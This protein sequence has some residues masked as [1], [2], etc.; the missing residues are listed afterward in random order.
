MLTSVF[1]PGS[2]VWFYAVDPAS[3]EL[4]WYNS[5]LMEEKVTGRAAQT[6]L[7]YV[8]T[9][10]LHVQVKIVTAGYGRVYLKSTHRYCIN[11]ASSRAN[12]FK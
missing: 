11:V 5:S 3:Q 2:D 1:L 12:L 4:L 9:G 8:I 7:K 10:D 6:N